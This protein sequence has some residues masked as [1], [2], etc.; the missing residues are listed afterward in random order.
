MPLTTQNPY[1]EVG[2]QLTAGLT[3]IAGTLS[4]GYTI[5]DLINAAYS[6]VESQYWP[7]GASTQI[8][9]EL[10]SIGRTGANSFVNNLVLG[11]QAGYNASQMGFILSLIGNPMTSNMPLVSI[12]D[13]IADVEDNITDN[14]LTVAEQTPLL[15]ATTIGTNADVYWNQVIAAGNASP[16]YTYYGTL[17]GGNLNIVYWDAAAMNGA[18]A[19]YGATP[20]SMVEPSVNFVTNKMASALMAALVCSAGK[21]I[22]NWIPRAQH[23]NPMVN[24]GAGAIYGGGGAPI[25]GGPA[26]GISWAPW[27]N[28][29]NADWCVGTITYANGNTVSWM[30]LK[31]IWTDDPY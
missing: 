25:G 27:G 14:Q 5:N 21:V 16:W 31:S 2:Q 6:Y 22:F 7:G 20:G 26:T 12:A 30:A 10:K 18:L 23:I 17:N 13:R 11:G 9:I 1:A 24:M 29:G 28:K 8:E 4:G 19:G 15:L 3:S